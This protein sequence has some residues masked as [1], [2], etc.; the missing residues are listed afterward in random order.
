MIRLADGLDRGRAQAVESIEV[1]LG[2]SLVV[3]GLNAQRDTELE[4]WGARRKR[5]LFEKLF[6]R[7]LEITT[8]AVET[9][10]S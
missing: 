8:R 6:D 4:V 5:E 7:D 10:R 3:L 1:R 2:P 9:R